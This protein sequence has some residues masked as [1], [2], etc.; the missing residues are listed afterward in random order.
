MVVP[1]GSLGEAAW[2]G[3]SL[4]LVKGARKFGMEGGE[5]CSRELV[6]FVRGKLG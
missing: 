2:G 5:Y 1:E 3:V 6:E 4:K